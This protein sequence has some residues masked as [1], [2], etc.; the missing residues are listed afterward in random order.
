MGLVMLIGVEHIVHV[1]QKPRIVS[2]NCLEMA[3][4]DSFSNHLKHQINSDMKRFI[5]V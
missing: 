5:S 3:M 2:F 1:I 4:R